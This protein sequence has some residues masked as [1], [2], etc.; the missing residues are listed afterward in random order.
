MR[1]GW[2]GTVLVFAL[3]VVA[4]AGL[5]EVALRAFGLGD[6]VLYDNR[7]A[8]GY[9][10][11]PDQTRRRIGGA[12]VHVNALGVRG[13]D[14]AATRPPGVVRLLFLGDS[15]TW[16]GS[17]VDDDALF[18]AVAA[19]ALASRGFRVE[20]LDA[21]VNGWGPQNI[22]GLVGESGGFDSSVW[23]VTALEDDFRREKTHVG[24]VPYMN[25]SPHTAWEE[26]L[27]LGSYKVVTAYKTA[28]P[29]ADLE[30][31]ADENLATYRAIAEAGRARGVRVLLVWHPTI[32]AVAGAAESAR[33]RYL[34]LA[35]AVGA[36]GLD[37]T[38]IYHA[39][40]K[41]LYVDGLHLSAEGHRVAGDAIGAAVAPLLAPNG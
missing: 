23:I 18:A 26:L 24:E 21:G 5:G 12:R 36:V 33:A 6:P 1:S 10:P 8:Y 32:E 14:V 29:A 4:A 40:G 7:L 38:P 39:G 11:L 13:P 34:D 35:P 3:G 31:L 2:L 25:R 19:R 16:G 28:K 30:R 41:D 9:R 22:L 17:Y 27:V 15:V 20:W 37:L